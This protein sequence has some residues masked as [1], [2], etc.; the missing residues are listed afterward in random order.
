[1][2]RRWLYDPLDS[3]QRDRVPHDPAARLMV[4]MT[5]AADP[6]VTPRDDTIRPYLGD[7]GSHLACGLRSRL[8]CRIR[9]VEKEGLGAE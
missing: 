6:R 7:D 5:H 2:R 3:G 4:G 1:V 8:Q 9:E